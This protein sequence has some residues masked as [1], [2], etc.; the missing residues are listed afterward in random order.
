MK[1]LYTLFDNK[2]DAVIKSDVLGVAR[3]PEL[4][5][6]LVP[7][8]NLKELFVDSPQKLKLRFI[9]GIDGMLWFAN[10]GRPSRTTPAH[11]QMTGADYLDAQC[12][13]AGNFS[14]KKENQ[15]YSLAITN[16]SGDFKPNLECLKWAIAILA[17][18]LKSSPDLLNIKDEIKIQSSP[19]DDTQMMVQIK[20]EETLAW[21][22]HTFS[23]EKIDVFQNQAVQKKDI[24]Y[25]PDAK[26]LE[27]LTIRAN[28]KR[29]ILPFADEV[30][31][32]GCGAIDEASHQNLEIP[33]CEVKRP[34][35]GFFDPLEDNSQSGQVMFD[36]IDKE[37]VCPKITLPN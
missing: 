34:K 9:V 16:K 28:R 35:F 23:K 17:L 12:L 11:Y 15:Q 4:N 37:M 6:K 31:N 3:N 32:I 10:E 18:N 29:L 36:L 21:V 13:A 19:S 8:A 1:S 27:T 20:S 7:L 22:E 25:T 30:E 33:K 5:C 14:F 26:N 2:V 24:Q